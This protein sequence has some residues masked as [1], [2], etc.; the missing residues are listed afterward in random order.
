MKKK[1]IICEGIHSANQETEVKSR[2]IMCY[3]FMETNFFYS[4]R[5]ADK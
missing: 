5:K 2:L 3:I 4:Y 1:Q